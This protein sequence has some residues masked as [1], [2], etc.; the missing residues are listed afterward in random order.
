VDDLLVCLR[1][2]LV[3]VYVPAERPEKRIEKFAP[4]FGLVLLP[5]VIDRAVELVALDKI[6]NCPG[7]RHQALRLTYDN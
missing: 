1:I 7:C 4:E 6:D 2:P 5:L 3:I